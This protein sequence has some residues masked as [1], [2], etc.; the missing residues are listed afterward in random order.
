[1]KR[2]CVAAVNRSEGRSLPQF[3]DSC[4]PFCLLKGEWRC[5]HWGK[6]TRGRVEEGSGQDTRKDD[7]LELCDV[8]VIPTH[9]I[10]WASP[11]AVG[12]VYK[13]L[14]RLRS[15]NRHLIYSPAVKHPRS[16]SR[17]TRCYAIV[18][19]ACRSCGRLWAGPG[20][21]SISLKPSWLLRTLSSARWSQIDKL[22]FRSVFLLSWEVISFWKDE[23]YCSFPLTGTSVCPL[24][25][26][27]TAE[28]FAITLVNNSLPLPLH[29]LEYTH[30]QAT[31]PLWNLIGQTPSHFRGMMLV[32]G[33]WLPL[34]LR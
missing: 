7:Q 3:G 30:L 23:H 13:S 6:W 32:F 11:P 29:W 2:M 21:K 22:V 18:Y 16:P 5:Y 25:S 8:W 31:L 15:W 14:L 28:C 19:P 33:L 20:P 34:N 12:D 4:P 10:V 17:V 9:K 1:M 27:I 24:A 26:K